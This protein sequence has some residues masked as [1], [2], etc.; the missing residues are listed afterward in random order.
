MIGIIEDIYLVIFRKWEQAAAYN[1][2][3]DH[4]KRLHS[5]WRDQEEKEVIIFREVEQFLWRRLFLFCSGKDFIAQWLAAL[6]NILWRG[7][8]EE[9]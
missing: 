8:K 6:Q 7:R 3:R 2:N 9:M 4:I 1:I 5:T